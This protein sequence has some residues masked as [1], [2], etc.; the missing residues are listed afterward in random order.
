M[1]NPNQAQRD[2]F[3]DVFRAHRS[4]HKQLPKASQWAM[5]VELERQLEKWRNDLTYAHH[6]DPAPDF[7]H[8]VATYEHTAQKYTEACRAIVDG[9]HQPTTTNEDEQ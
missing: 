4:Q 6:T 9:Y 8:R 1:L 5:L 2:L 3:A 7:A